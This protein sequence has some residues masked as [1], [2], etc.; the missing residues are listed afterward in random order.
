MLNTKGSGK[1]GTRSIILATLLM[2]VISSLTSVNS[3]HA[4]DLSRAP[5][6]KS[7]RTTPSKD[8]LYDLNLSST[9]DRMLGET[10][11]SDIHDPLTISSLKR[12][13]ERALPSWRPDDIDPEQ[14]RN[15][16]ER[17]LAFQSGRTI[18]DLLRNSELKGVYRSIRQ[19]FSD[20][21][22]TFRYSVQKGDTGYTVSQAKKGSKL[23]EFNLEINP[24]QGLD[25]QV[26]I[27]D[28]TR[29][30]YDFSSQAPMLEYGFSF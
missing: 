10:S 26:R 12:L 30:R 25:P 7:L 11:T 15:V 5:V 14:T 8:P 4:D 21:Q 17:A 13:Q 3:A 23:M 29:F 16:A 2:I 9:L 6:G 28:N 18:H 27:G 19:A 22:D 1:R 24:K 20:F